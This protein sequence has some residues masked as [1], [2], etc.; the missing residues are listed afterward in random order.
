MLDG[1]QYPSFLTTE[2]TIPG[3]I[4]KAVELLEANGVTKDRILINITGGH[5]E[6]AWATRLPAA[7]E[8]LFHPGN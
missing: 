2:V 8:F 3:D 4:A 7:L 5:N 1:A 6:V